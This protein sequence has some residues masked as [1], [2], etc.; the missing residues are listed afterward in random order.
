MKNMTDGTAYVQGFLDR[1]ERVPAG[2]YQC[3]EVLA[4]P[5]DYPGRAR[6]AGREPDAPGGGFLLSE[7]PEYAVIR[8]AG[9][10][11]FMLCGRVS[12]GRTRELRET[13]GV[14]VHTESGGT[15]RITSVT[16]GGILRQ[17]L[18]GPEIPG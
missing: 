2:E 9:G 3:G 1:G 8:L 10:G 7:P 16:C 11:R 12:Q 4:V 17:E 6:R 18:E 5:G 13:R 15:A 14:H